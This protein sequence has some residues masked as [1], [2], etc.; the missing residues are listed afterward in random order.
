MLSSQGDKVLGKIKSWVKRADVKQPPPFWFNGRARM[1]MISH[2]IVKWADATNH[3]VLGGLFYFSQDKLPGKNPNSYSL[4]S[5][6]SWP[7]STTS[8]KI[9]LFITLTSPSTKRISDILTD[10]P[11]EQFRAL[12]EE[13]WHN[14]RV[15]TEKDRVL[16][17]LD[18]IHWHDESPSDPGD[19]SR[20]S[21]RTLLGRPAGWDD[22]QRIPRIPCK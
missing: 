10:L 3:D 9:E 1:P 17:V 7:S 14:A 13:P 15:R 2:S 8:F 16:V 20:N 4:H 12:I 11:A 18:A 21:E 19:L 5:H 22:A 6:I